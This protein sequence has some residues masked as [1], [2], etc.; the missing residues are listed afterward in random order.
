MYIVSLSAVLELSIHSISKEETFALDRHRDTSDLSLLIDKKN[1]LVVSTK[2]ELTR[3]F[4][5]SL[6]GYVVRHFSFFHIQN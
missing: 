5:S 2:A 1:E 4:S 3:H 6:F